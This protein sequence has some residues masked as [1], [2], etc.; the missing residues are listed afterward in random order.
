MLLVLRELVEVTALVRTGD[1]V[2]LL[3]LRV[4][5]AVVVAGVRPAACIAL[6]ARVAVEVK[7]SRAAVRFD[8]ALRIAAVF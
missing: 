4:V 3:T 7:F 2:E 8:T 1:V 5:V 6:D